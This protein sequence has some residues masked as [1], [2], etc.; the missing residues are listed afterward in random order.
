M[1]IIVKEIVTRWYLILSDSKASRNKI[2][3]SQKINAEGRQAL[4][5]DLHFLCHSDM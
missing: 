5:Q 4:Q 3:F 2:G 1:C